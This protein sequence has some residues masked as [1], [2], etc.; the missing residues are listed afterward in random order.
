MNSGA[1]YV[2]IAIYRNRVMSVKPSP[3]LLRISGTHQQRL[4]KPPLLFQAFCAR[5]LY[6]VYFALARVD[7]VQLLRQA[8]LVG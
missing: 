1:S 2:T 7:C 6:C 5:F 3:S 4:E 8:D